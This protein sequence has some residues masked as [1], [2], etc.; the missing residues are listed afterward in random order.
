M[1]RV[2]ISRHLLRLLLYD[3]L[4]LRVPRDFFGRA[5]AFEDLEYTIFREGSHAA[6]LRRRPQFASRG[7]LVRQFPQLVVHFYHFEDTQPAFVARVVTGGTARPFVDRPLLDL[8]R[9]DSQ[10]PEMVWIRVLVHH[11][12]FLADYP[13]QPLRH[14]SLY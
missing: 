3:S 2:P 4:D 1:F 7:S 14:D 11:L 13:H 10:K 5:N 9:V 12:A 8:R 6:G